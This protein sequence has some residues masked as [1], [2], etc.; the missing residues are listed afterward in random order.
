M[1]RATLLAAALLALSAASSPAFTADSADPPVPAAVFTD[2]PIDPAHPPR[3][4]VLHIPSGGVQINGVIYLAAGAGPHPTVILL[5]GLPGNEKMQDLAQAIRR[6]GWNC[7]AFNYRGSW[8]SPGAFSLEGNIVDAKALLS[9]VRDPANVA[10]FQIDTRKLVLAGHSM[11]GWVTALTAA[12]DPGLAGAVLISAA[13]MAGHGATP[14]VRPR[15]VKSMESE[16]ESLAGTSREKLADEIIGAS[17]RLSFN[18][19]VAKGLTDKPQLILTSND[20]LAPDAEGLASKIQGDGGTRVSVHHEATDHAWSG[21]RIA[22]EAT[23]IRW[24]QGLT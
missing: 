23:V 5:H 4:D 11:G 2:P 13:D 21:I 3:M 22:L 14:A 12:Q 10:A 17:P 16:M 6:A 19:A 24:L 1:T 8:G 18:A 15:V 7:I 20:G 9:F